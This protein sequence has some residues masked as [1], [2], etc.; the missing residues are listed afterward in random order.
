MCVNGCLMWSWS[1]GQ[2][3]TA[4]SSGESEF[5]ALILGATGALGLQ[6]TLADLGIKAKI[7]LR[8]DST[9][10]KAMC[11]R[12]GPGAHLKHVE[13]RFF[14][15]QQVMA[16]RL[17]DVEKVDG[18]L[19]V[20]DLLTKAVT[21]KTFKRLM[22]MTGMR[23]MEATSVGALRED[24]LP[25]TWHLTPSEKKIMFAIIGALNISMVKGSNEVVLSEDGPMWIR[26]P[27]MIGGTEIMML[28]IFA[29]GIAIGILITLLLSACTMMFL[30][31][32]TTQAVERRVFSK[33]TGKGKS[34]RLDI[35][36][37]A[38]LEDSEE[39]FRS[40]I[41]GRGRDPAPP[42]DH[43]AAPY[44]E[45]EPEDEFPTARDVATR[46]EAVPP[47]PNSIF[48]TVRAGVRFH[49]HRG[50]RGL[51]IAREVKEFTPCRLCW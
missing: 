27:N 2:T 8:T 37:T 40:P 32:K 14:M 28:G 46:T 51:L 25:I 50:C 39:E 22:P 13:T 47:P 16:S 30:K 5:Y 43:G 18:E 1:K 29:L 9:A 12:L 3:V 20:S 44:A 41:P 10:A 23:T 35:Y 19:N 15:L 21:P 26:P 6:S 31:R 49:S 33:G 4:Q 17:L 42:V 7:L 36:T 24:V 38:L 48:T 45:D 34:K 11:F